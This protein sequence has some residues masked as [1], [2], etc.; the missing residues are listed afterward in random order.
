MTP[1]DD[2]QRQLLFDYSL[3]MTSRSETAEAQ[4]LLGS[5]QEAAELHDMLQ[6]VLAPLA[7][8]KSEPCPD[9]LTERLFLRL[10]SAASAASA[11]DLRY[12][13]S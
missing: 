8:L 7:S 13:G 5:N 6:G 12:A 1:L 11:M 3:G 10:N 4:R 2:H 9:H